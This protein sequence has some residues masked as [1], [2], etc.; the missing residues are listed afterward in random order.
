MAVFGKN[1]VKEA[2]AH[3]MTRKT[4]KPVLAYSWQVNDQL[5]NGSATIVMTFGRATPTSYVAI[6]EEGKEFW[7]T[8]KDPRFT[9]AIDG[10]DIAVTGLVADFKKRKML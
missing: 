5:K 10:G 7:I 1:Q 3:E 9:C 8:K 6:D 2:F 4:G